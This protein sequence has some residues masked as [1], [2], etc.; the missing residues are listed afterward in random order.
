MGIGIDELKY[1]TFLYCPSLEKIVLP[2][3]VT[4]IGDGCFYGC[5]NLKEI[6]IPGAINYIGGNEF[7][8]PTV[9]TVYGISGSYTEEWAESIGA[10][11]VPYE[12]KATSIYLD[13]TKVELDKGEEIQLNINVRPYDCTERIEWTSSNKWIAYVYSNGVIEGWSGGTATITAKVGDLTATCEVTVIQEDTPVYVEIEGST[14]E[15]TS[16]EIYDTN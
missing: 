13:K 2:Y 16:F 6:V 5:N 4:S 14:D 1:S 7:T 10:T 11:F 12:K 3:S 9:I 15:N 8:D